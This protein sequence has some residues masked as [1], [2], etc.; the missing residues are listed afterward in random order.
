[1][2]KLCPNCGKNISKDEANFCPECGA[3]FDSKKINIPKISYHEDNWIK[4]ILWIDDVK[5]GKSRISKAKLIGLVIF[6]G[7]IFYSIFNCGYYIRRGFFTFVL[8]MFTS[9]IAGLIY[10]CICRGIGFVVRKIR[11]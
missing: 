6:L 1:M 9:F 11:K 7:Y 4:N 2:T 3:S 5:T 8:M 10:Y